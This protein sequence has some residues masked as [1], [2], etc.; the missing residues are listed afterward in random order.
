MFAYMVR[1]KKQN[2]NIFINIYGNYLKTEGII[3]VCI[4]GKNLNY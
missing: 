1:I 4:Y 3:F 2:E